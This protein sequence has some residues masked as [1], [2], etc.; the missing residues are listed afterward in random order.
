[1]LWVLVVLIV[2]SAS[3]LL[4]AA[5]GPMRGT[6]GALPLTVVSVV[7]YLLAAVLAGARLMGVA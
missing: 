3:G 2:L 1:M 5:R 7:Q 4:Y 6:P